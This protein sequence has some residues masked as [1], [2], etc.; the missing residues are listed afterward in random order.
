MEA[1]A[2]VR[3]CATARFNESVDVAIRLNIDAQRTDERVRG[4]ANLPH[5]TGKEARVAV[6]T[7][8]DNADIAR[9]A[10]ADIVG[11]EDLVAEVVK[12][13]IDFSRCLATPDMMP[14]LA[15]AA[16]VLGPRNLMPNPKRGSVV[17]DVAE[18]VKR[19]KSGEIEFRASLKHGIVLSS[20]GKADFSSA[21]LCDNG[22]QLLYTH[23]SRCPLA[24]SPPH[25]DHTYFTSP[26]VTARMMWQETELPPLSAPPLTVSLLT[27]HRH[28][29]LEA[30]PQR[31]R[32]KPPLSITLSSSLGPGVRLDHRLWADYRAP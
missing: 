23:A 25:L 30:R 12:G 5:S 2:L 21:V 26:L 7:R 6:F 22:L 16:R 1:L 8:G 19:A 29:V 20:I 14:V 24:P 10:G 17:T 27:R 4:R 13:N 28:D 3:A 18:A 15:K 9:A 31:F 11:A 32:A